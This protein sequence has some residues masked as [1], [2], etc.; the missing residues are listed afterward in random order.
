[1]K[2]L[3]LICA[4]LMLCGFTMPL[5]WKMPDDSNHE[6]FIVEYCRTST[7]AKNC[8]RSA[9]GWVNWLRLN[10]EQ[11]V[12]V[13]DENKPGQH[14]YRLRSGIGADDDNILLSEPSNNKCGFN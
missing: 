4:W 13:V 9:S 5:E 1:V 7:N 6:F 3:M 10:A 8:L 2:L 14:C 11:R 12:I